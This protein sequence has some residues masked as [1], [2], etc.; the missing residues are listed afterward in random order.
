L[1]VVFV[2]LSDV[3]SSKCIDICWVP[4]ARATVF[5]I[6]VLWQLFLCVGRVTSRVCSYT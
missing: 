6:Y 1:F 3:D 5:L 2:V 4:S